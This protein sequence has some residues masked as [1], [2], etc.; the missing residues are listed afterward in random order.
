MIVIWGFSVFIWIT[1][2]FL[3]GMFDSGDVPFTSAPPESASCDTIIESGH[4][5][6]LVTSFDVFNM[7]QIDLVLF[8]PSVPVPN[9]CFVSATTTL[10]MWNFSFFNNESGLNMIRWIVFLPLSSI[11]FMGTIVYIGPIALQTM[12]VIRNMFRV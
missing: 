7:H 10:A 12:Y 9:L 4:S 11:V 1:A 3:G 2:T 6:D 5:L 8:N